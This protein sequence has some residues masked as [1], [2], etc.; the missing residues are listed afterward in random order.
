MGVPIFGTGKL[1]NL[2]GVS[3]FRPYSASIGV[4]LTQTL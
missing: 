1:G 3:P 4:S 2:Q